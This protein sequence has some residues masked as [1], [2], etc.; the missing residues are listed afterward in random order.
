VRVTKR[1]GEL[2]R[3]FH[4]YGEPFQ[5]TYGTTVDVYESSAAMEPCVWLKLTQGGSLHFEE[6]EGVAH[7]DQ[8]QVLALIARLQASV[9][10]DTAAVAAMTDRGERGPERE[11]GQA[12]PLCAHGRPRG[13]DVFGPDCDATC[14]SPP[15]PPDYVFTPP[16]EP[17]PP[18]PAQAQENKCGVED[19]NDTVPHIHPMRDLEETGRGRYRLRAVQPVDPAREAEVRKEALAEK[20]GCEICDVSCSC[21]SDEGY[22]PGPEPSRHDWWVCGQHYTEALDAA[23]RQSEEGLREALRAAWFVL[24]DM[25]VDL[26]EDRNLA[27]KA[28]AA[29]RAALEET[30]KP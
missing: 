7:L 3:G 16:D 4:Q 27:V 10:R 18:G 5:C 15:E 9:G 1:G 25:A 26:E 30:P 23:R 22:R 28:E 2:G 14:A 13:G 6:G 17:E 11:A 21:W 12:E 24:R 8:E 20:P 29:A 19:C